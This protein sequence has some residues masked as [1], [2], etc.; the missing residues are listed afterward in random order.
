[1]GVKKIEFAKI[2]KYVSVDNLHVTQRLIKISNHNNKQFQRMFPELKDQDAFDCFCDDTLW[3]VNR[4]YKKE[5]KALDIDSWSGSYRVD[6]NYTFF[7]KKLF[8][9]R[10]S[11]ILTE[12][13]EI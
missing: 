8:V 10:V 6:A 9:D 11:A 2:G 12:T 7:G 4:L 3:L 5:L 1:M 13:V